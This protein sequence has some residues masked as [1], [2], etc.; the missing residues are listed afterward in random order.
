MT[1]LITGKEFDGIGKTA[2]IGQVMGRGGDEQENSF[3]DL[4]DHQASL[5]ELFTIILPHDLEDLNFV[6]T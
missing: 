1:L 6:H 2:L 5:I 3:V 4:Q